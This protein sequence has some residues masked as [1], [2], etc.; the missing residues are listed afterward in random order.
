[1]SSLQSAG[2]TLYSASPTSGPALTYSTSIIST[3][4]ISLASCPASRTYPT[5]S[6][7]SLELTTF[8]ATLASS[9][10]T[11]FTS[12]APSQVLA[13]SSLTYSSYLVLGLALTYLAS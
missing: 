8:L 1:M 7:S 2:Q 10:L 4:S 5:S 11:Y 13:S 9:P 6:D 3:Y 12:L